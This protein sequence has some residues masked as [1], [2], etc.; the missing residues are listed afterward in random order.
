[1]GI[2]D[3]ISK[4]I[5]GQAAKAA[6]TQDAGRLLKDAAPAE[7]GKA[8]ALA[9]DS[10]Q[11]VERVDPNNPLLDTEGFPMGTFTPTKLPANFNPNPSTNPFLHPIQA[12][13]GLF[14]LFNFLQHGE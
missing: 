12:I 8:P 11:A 14:G 5:D 7:L 10:Y 3:L 2:G 6:A 1:M 13:K 4:A 9:S